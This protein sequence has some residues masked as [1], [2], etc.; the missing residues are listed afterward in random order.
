M[1]LTGRWNFKEEFDSG[2]DEGIAILAH[3]GERVYGMLDFTEY[4]DEETPFQ[5]K[6]KIEGSVI[7]DKVKMEMVDI[8][9]I[10]VEPIEYFPEIREGIINAKGQ[11]VGSSEDEQGICGVFVFEKA[12]NQ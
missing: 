12:N 1:D 8:E 10:S 2:K 6:C 11:I 4:I 5:V 3:A 9:V 7:G